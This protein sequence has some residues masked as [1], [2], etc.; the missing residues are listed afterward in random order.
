MCLKWFSSYLLGRTQ[1]VRINDTDSE[2]V[3]VESGVPQGSVLGPILYLIY[4]NDVGSVNINSTVIMFADDSVLITSHRDPSIAVENLGKDLEY[5]AKYFASLKLCLNAKKTKNLNIDKKIK[6]TSVDRFPPLILKGEVIESVGVFNYLGIKID[7]ELK[8]KQHLNESI[9]RAHGKLYMLGKVRRYM[10][11]GTAL[12]LFK[13]MV[14][15]YIEYGNS[16]LLGID[17]ASLCKLQRA[18]NRGLKVAL[19]R[20]MRYNTK[21]LHKEAN[22]ASWEVRARIA[23]MC[24]MFKY[25]QSDEYIVNSQQGLLTRSHDGPLFRID[26]PNT[27]RFSRSCSYLGRIEWNSSP[28]Y[29]RCINDYKKFKSEVKRLYVHRYFE[30]LTDDS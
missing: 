17:A 11:S 24:L 23:L 4:V 18:Q 22:L 1:F 3:K 21:I 27:T 29:I 19:G 20:D 9:K 15:P 12:K 28:S 13:C 26:R 16:F 2:V 7:K 25:K 10:D 30:S 14:L 6:K 5:I 8:M